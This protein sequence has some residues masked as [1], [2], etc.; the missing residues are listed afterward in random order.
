MIKKILIAALIFLLAIFAFKT[1]Q[2]LTGSEINESPAIA[3]ASTLRHTPAGSVEGFIDQHNAHAWLG[4]PYAQAPVGDLR[5]RAPRPLKAWTNTHEALAYADDCA[6]IG[7]PSLYIDSSQFDQVVG[8][9]DCLYLNIWAP[10]FNPKLIPEGDKRLP[11]MVWIHGGGNTVGSAS[12]YVG[13]ALAVKQNVI[14]VSM[15]YR[16]GILG[17]FRHPHL[18]P[19][20]ASA[21]DRSGN[22]ATLDLIESLK[23]VR[24]NISAFGGDPD[25]VTIFGESAGGR[26]VYSLLASPIAKDLFHGAIVQ[27]GSTRT[28]PISW[29]ENP[30]DHSERGAEYSSH[31]ILQKLLATDARTSGTPSTPTTIDQHKVGDYLRNTSVN[32]L[33]ASI[34]GA[35]AGMYAAPQIFRDGWVMPKKPLIEVFNSG[36][37]NQVPIITGSNRDEFKL[38]FL[39]SDQYTQW[40]GPIPRIRDLQKY[41]E[42]SAYFSD[43]WKIM[44]VDEPAAAFAHHQAD[45]IFAYRFDW[46]EEPNNWLVQLD[47]LMGAS[48]SFEINFVFGDFDHGVRIPGIYT[49]EN[50]AGRLQLSEA[51]MNYWGHFAYTGKPGTG[52]S[53]DFPLWKPWQLQGDKYLIFDTEADGGIRLSRELVTISQLKQRLLSDKQDSQKHRCSFYAELFLLSFQEA[54]HWDIDEYNNFGDGGCADYPAWA[55]MR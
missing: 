44:A 24:E 34:D 42:K 28:D 16:L 9:E 25:R 17:W 18:Q 1:Y 14:V 21:E 6:Q 4:I 2:Y 26:N 48:H 8:A 3:D 53:G 27:S 54:N 38:M 7:G 47:Q 51:M 32:T 43:H 11:V 40:L 10:A 39:Q 33:L 46:D 31:S 49:E 12:T 5:W 30:V 55:F 22:Y 13:H 50:L 41:N 15:N 52:R 19:D 35:S 36:Q 37:Y 29:A 20:D 23:W 45:A